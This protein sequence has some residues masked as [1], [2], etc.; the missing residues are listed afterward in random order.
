MPPELRGKYQYW[1]EA[2]I[3]RL[4]ATGYGQPISDLHDA[5]RDYVTQYLVTDLHLGDE[6]ASTNPY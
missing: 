4:R 2:S 5:V 6:L 3:D 1:T